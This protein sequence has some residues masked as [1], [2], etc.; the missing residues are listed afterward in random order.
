MKRFVGSSRGLK[1]LSQFACRALPRPLYVS[2]TRAIARKI[3]V[4]SAADRAYLEDL[5]RDDNE[6]L[7]HLIGISFV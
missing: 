7:A 4:T 5:F 1:S 2:L 3:P 6:N